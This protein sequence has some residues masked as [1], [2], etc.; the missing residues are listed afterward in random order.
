MT[1]GTQW[2]RGDQKASWICTSWK[3]TAAR[4][5]DGKVLGAGTDIGPE[6]ICY[7]TDLFKAAGLPTDRTELAAKWSTWDRMTWG[8]VAGTRISDT[9]ADYARSIIQH[10]SGP[11]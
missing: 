9:S 10:P 3:G 2:P 1:A 4:T 8:N 11:V 6:A 7:R 5:A